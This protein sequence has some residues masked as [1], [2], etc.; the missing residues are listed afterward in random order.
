MNN[1]L[2]FSL[3][4]LF[5]TFLLGIFVSVFLEFVI[6]RT[7]VKFFKLGNYGFGISTIVLIAVFISYIFSNKSLINILF[8]NGCSRKQIS[9]IK[10]LSVMIYNLIFFIIYLLAGYFFGGLSE[11][12]FELNEFIKI[13]II[14]FAINLTAEIGTFLVL[15]YRNL[16]MKKGKGV[17]KVFYKYSYS[18]IFII[19][20]YFVRYFY[21]PFLNWNL[22]VNILIVV[23]AVLVVLEIALVYVN[24]KHILNIDVRF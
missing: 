4:S 7:F 1:G 16:S 23:L 5:E 12:L 2:K 11:K 13:G 20:I 14:F 3:K 8:I 21:G 17:I 15:I 18:F 24:K 22:N 19:L 10:I 6:Y 9:R